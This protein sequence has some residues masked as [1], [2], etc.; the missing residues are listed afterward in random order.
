MQP[1]YPPMSLQC[2]VIHRSTLLMPATPW[3]PAQASI[4]N[5]LWPFNKLCNLC[6]FASQCLFPQCRD[7]SKL[8]Q[9][10]RSPMLINPRLNGLE[11]QS[12]ASNA[13]M[14]YAS[15]HILSCTDTLAKVISP[16]I[17]SRTCANPARLKVALTLQPSATRHITGMIWTVNA[18]I[19]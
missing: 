18:R 8:K 19:H 3:H 4:K 13:Q 1:G 10:W 9:I 6:N 15:A 5:S 14:I 2:I 16:Q 12:C 17:T 7:C 11:K